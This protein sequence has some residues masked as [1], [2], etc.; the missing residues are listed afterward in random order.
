[1]AKLIIEGSLGPFAIDAADGG[2]L[3]DF[4]DATL[5]P[6]RFSCRSASC[7]TCRVD[8]LEGAGELEAPDDEERKTLEH[9]GEDPG[10]RRLACVARVRAGTGLLRVRSRR[11]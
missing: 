8:V 3:A 2:A 7:G 5:A 4:C 1:M 9:L 11:D 10:R 6:L